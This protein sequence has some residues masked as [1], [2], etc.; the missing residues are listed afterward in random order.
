MVAHARQ[1]RPDAPWLSDSYLKNAHDPALSKTQPASSRACRA[2]RARVAHDPNAKKGIRDP[3]AEHGYTTLGPIASGAFSTIQRAMHR[4]SGR[5]V[6]VKSFV[7]K[8]TAALTPGER[9]LGK[10]DK[11]DELGQGAKELQILRL[12]APS[13]H[14]GVANL[15]S[16]V[17]SRR[18]VHAVLEYCVGGSLSHLLSSRSEGFGLDE[19]AAAPVIAQANAALAHLHQI[20][21]THR[22]VK[23][24]NL[25]FVDAERRYVK[26]CDFGFASRCMAVGGDGQLPGGAGG[27]GGGAGSSLRRR[28]KTLCGTPM[29]QAPELQM[30][31]AGGYEGPPVDMWSLGA[32]AYEV[33]HGRPA[34]GGETM[35]VLQL[36]ISRASHG[37]LS[38]ALSPAARALVRALLHL[39]PAERPAAHAVAAATWIRDQQQLLAQEGDYYAGAPGRTPAL[40]QIRTSPNPHAG[41]GGGGAA[42]AADSALATAYAIDA[43][44]ATAAAAVAAAPI[45]SSSPPPPRLPEISSPAARMMA[46]TAAAAALSHSP[47]TEEP[48]LAASHSQRPQHPAAARA[49]VRAGGFITGRH[50]QRTEVGLVRVVPQPAAGTAG[51]AGIAAAAAGGQQRQRWRRQQQEQATIN[52]GAPSRQLTGG[53]NR[54]RVGVRDLRRAQAQ[55]GGEQQAT[56]AAGGLHLPRIVRG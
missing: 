3:L 35:E 17:E 36:R 21:V 33:L 45:I 26:L 27:D 23:P 29:Y 31:R 2:S 43:A 52:F 5:E 51:T 38:S 25:L 54:Q 12:L 46:T 24:A 50:Q 47:Y 56:Q 53:E 4:K 1:P 39:H 14:N 10:K 19:R 9:A 8:K 44:A 30:S 48:R 41:G 32:V 15:V 18:A 7:K 16:V 55:Q 49:G 42:A 28:L 22:D 34:F 40:P 37:R 6:A 13:Q 20:G 11:G